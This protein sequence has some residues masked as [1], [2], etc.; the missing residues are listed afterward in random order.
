[1]S[2]KTVIKEHISH[3]PFKDHFGHKAQIDQGAVDNIHFDVN[4]FTNPKSLKEHWGYFIRDRNPEKN[5]NGNELLIREFNREDMNECVRLFSRVF[6]TDPWNDNWVS[7]DQ[8][9]Y[10]LM[11][12]IENPVFMGFVAY[13]GV[14]LVAVCL[15]HRRSFWM[16]KE[17]FVDEFFVEND[18]QGNGIG[19]RT[20]DII[21]NYLIKEGYSRLTLLTNE[22]IPAESFYL[23]NGFYNNLKRTV[24][25]REL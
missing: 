23:K 14:D 4:S 12:L 11:E 10:Y 1:M 19:T 18:R 24:M 16:G 15:G 25:V 9:K 8:V 20:M 17:L 22:G 7:L 21:T 3:S 2:I 6:S 13:E 5:Y